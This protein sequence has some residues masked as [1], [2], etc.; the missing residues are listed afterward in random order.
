[1]RSAKRL[2]ELEERDDRRIASA[3]FEVRK[4]LLRESGRV[5][6]FFL[7]E[8]AFE[9][10]PSYIPPNQ[11]P[12]V[13]GG[14]LAARHTLSLS[15]IVCNGGRKQPLEM[16]HSALR[17]LKDMFEGFSKEVPQ[18]EHLT[19]YDRAHVKDYLR[20]LD[21]TEEGADWREVARVL[22]GIDPA[23]REKLARQVYNAHLSR[24]RWMTTHGYLDLLK[25]T[26]K[27]D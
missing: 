15:S 1:M 25:S 9:P 7:R 6:E 16:L 8:A 3:A 17:T 24:A 5:G 26:C 27:R 23:R 2:G 11:A 18:S 21:A 4:I 19:D 22:F 20:L 13:H 12:H 14:R 10:Q